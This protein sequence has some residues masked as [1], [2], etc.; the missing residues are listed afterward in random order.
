[1]QETILDKVQVN[2][3]P[4]HDLIDFEPRLMNDYRVKLA[5]KKWIALTENLM[6]RFEWLWRN[7]G[8]RVAGKRIVYRVF[9]LARISTSG[10]VKT[11]VMIMISKNNSFSI[12]TFNRFRTVYHKKESWDSHFN[13]CIPSFNSLG[14][15]QVN[16][17][18]NYIEETT[19]TDTY[20]YT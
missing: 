9:H 2:R 4:W 16:N 8:Q 13:V 1:M 6:D 15:H 3:N 14:H 19:R 17:N 12:A 10:I 11:R 18:M 5:T 7:V 20:R